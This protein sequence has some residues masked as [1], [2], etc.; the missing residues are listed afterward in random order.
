MRLAQ[1]V[2]AG[3]IATRFYAYIPSTVTIPNYLG[4]FELWG[5]D[6]GSDGKISLEAKPNDAFE[7][8]V[9]PNGTTHLSAAGAVLRDQ[10]LCLSLTVSV[11]ASGGAISLS[12]NGAPVIDHQDVV[13]ALP[14]A[15]SV[16]VVEALPSMDATGIDLT[17]DDLVVGTEPL[18]CPGAQ[19]P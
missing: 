13:A 7:V 14:S 4:L 19:S 9:T 3:L 2:S 11:A 1:S 18:P 5:D 10:W 6:T 17:L 12:V 15:I 16:A 8:Y